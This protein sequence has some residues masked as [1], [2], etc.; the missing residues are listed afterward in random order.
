MDIKGLSQQQVNE[1][2]QQGRVN[3]QPENLTIT[4]KQILRKNILTL[5][6]LIN[7]V[8]AAILIAVGGQFREILFLGFIVSNSS[9]GIIQELRSK[10]TLDRL[11]IIARAKAS[12]MRDGQIISIS[13]EDVVI[14]DVLCIETGN[15]IC[16]DSEVIFSEGCEVD[17]SLLTGEPDKVLKNTGD[18][19]MSGS[20]IVSGRAFARVT[21]VGKDNYATALTIEAKKEKKQNSK[22]L[23]NINTI[24]KILTIVIV[25]LGAILFYR[26][27]TIA[28]DLLGS[29]R[30]VSQSI[31]GMIPEGL[32][33]LTS[34]TLTVGTIKL[35]RQKALV[36]SMSSIETLARVDVICLDKTGTITD[37]TIAFEKFILPQG[38]SENEIKYIIAEAMGAIGD[39][40]T[41][42]KAL[43]S[44]FGSHTSW[45]STIKVPFSS[46]RKWSGAYFT[47]F[48]SY[49]LGAPQFVFPGENQSFFN[50][51]REYSEKGYRVLCL[52]HSDME[53]VNNQLPLDLKCIGLLI[54]SDNIRK[55]A[56]DT[57]KFFREEGVG[58]RVISGDDPLT[59]SII[60]SKA[61][62]EGSELYVD[63]SKYPEQFDFSDLVEKYIIFG[64]V[65]PR[66]KKEL[67][68][69]LKRNGHITCMT[70]D[71]VN[72]V[73]AMK[74]ADCSIAMIN[75]SD[76]ARGASDFVLMTS[77]FSAMKNVLHEGR[78]VINNIENVSSMYL[79]KTI[80][81]T[82]LAIL[83]I[84]IPYRYPFTTLSI[85][86]INTFT[87]GI[88]SFFLAL[89]KNTKKPE[90][91]FLTN[92]LE[93]SLPA[94]VSVVMSIMVIQLAG[95][96]FNIF[97][98][99]DLIN[100][101]MLTMYALVTGAVCFALIF[102]ISK[103]LN[104]MTK[105][106]MVCLVILFAGVFTI[107][108]FRDY[109]GFS[110]VFTRNIFF[111]LPLLYIGPR[112]FLILNNLINKIVCKFK[113]AK[114]RY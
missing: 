42:A 107:P 19:L 61:G 86:P 4:L 32:I 91:K 44:S 11:S 55:E 70:G 66:Q 60:A 113:K 97:H 33:L 2:K 23:G 95:I 30:G 22:L 49:I 46:E 37:G 31:L 7:I 29:V 94:A 90:G 99:P 43:L 105:V 36:Q 6:N 58:F 12:V 77:N 20:F 27:Y 48:G 21:A 67:V 101:D 82:L 14:D 78:R 74:E 108:L 26:Q 114:E 51:V 3:T 100:S 62:I 109:F 71:G 65:S 83:Y 34:I 5:F 110:G 72:D 63:M 15:Q 111:Y 112:L 79:V 56:P 9:M 96:L 1:R 68:S 40:N 106:L 89:R 10:R 50:S 104:L 75:G 38:A 25:P 39:N 87:I 73:L 64:R 76:A 85:M 59:V 52:A 103:P 57:F 92:V 93:N 41:T 45:K 28:N 17:E 84:I 47:N 35:A 102:K 24:I 81:S 54:M 80:Y 53:I 13:Q 88:P 18:T 69:A 16:A 98:H 8:I